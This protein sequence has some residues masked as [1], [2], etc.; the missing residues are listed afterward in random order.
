MNYNRRKILK[1]TSS[2]AVGGVFLSVAGR[3]VWKMFTHPEE[4]FND[5]KRTRSPQLLKEDDA[6]V[7][8][9]RRI[10][11]FMVPDEIS[12]MEVSG[13]SIYLATP[14]HICVYG[15][16][17][18]LQSQFSASS[19]H[20][21]DETE[22]KAVLARDITVFE[23]RIYVLFPTSIAVYD[24]QGGALQQI[25]AC[26]EES[27]Y[28]SIAVCPEGIFVTDVGAKNIC[29][30]NMDGTLARFI[31]SP[32]GFVVPSYSFAITYVPAGGQASED[33]IFCSNPGRHL[34]ESYTTEGEYIASFGEAGAQPGAF[35]GCC[36]PTIITTRGSGELLTSEKGIPRISCYSLTGKFR[37]VL[38]DSKA[39]GGGHKAYDVRVLKDML[40]VC[41]GRK[42]SVFRYD[43]RLSQETKCGQ[44]TQD[45]PLKI[46]K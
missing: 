22:D 6:F 18:E 44:C 36:N 15:I 27:D 25:E 14:G 41:G 13:G 37:S 34:V 32:K 45:C 8:P 46:D 3:S 11:G 17:G 9:Y 4:L 26:S 23:D 33:R 7:S 12:A 30:Y 10:A 38:L 35:S 40:I 2:L 29:K 19:S 42:V 5:S 1:A 39:L 24:R 16:S 20:S 28:C 21:S 43:K 31:Q